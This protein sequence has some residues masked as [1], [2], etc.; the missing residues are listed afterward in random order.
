MSAD[1]MF[2]T[3]EP[4]FLQTDVAALIAVRTAE[5]AEKRR[6][7]LIAAIWRGRGFPKSPALKREAFAEGRSDLKRHERFV[8]DM[9][10]GFRSVCYY[11]EPHESNQ[12]VMIYHQGHNHDWQASG[13]KE[14]VEFFL[15]RH[16]SV[17]VFTMPFFAENTGPLTNDGIVG[18]SIASHN[19]MGRFETDELNP[20]KFFIEPIAIA[21]NH[22]QE[23]Q[24]IRDI[25]MIGLSGGGW[26]TH[27]YA[28]VDPRIRLSFPVAGS[29]PMYLR[30]GCHRDRDRGDWEQFLP[31]RITCDYL[32]LYVL[33]AAGPDRS[34]IQ[35]INKYDSCCFGGIRHRT[36]ERH[37]KDAV[38]Q[39]GSGSFSV[40]LDDT[41]R[42]HLISQHTLDHA[43]APVLPR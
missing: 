40:F 41:H 31:D 17:L 37:V 33:A 39:T 20:V 9:D 28:A 12:R 36:Y 7:D 2:E 27:L 22:L 43:V 10:L 16:Y 5:Q 19:A 42:Q 18:N 32:D 3:I 23:T 29:V 26:T 11:L 15:A 14:T 24:S 25:G 1:D 8:I 35:V 6:K 4:L 34:Q 21:L 30:Q 13:G 38:A